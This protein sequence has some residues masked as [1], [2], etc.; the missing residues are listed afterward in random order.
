MSC[1][2]FACTVALEGEAVLAALLEIV[3]EH[4]LGDAR[5]V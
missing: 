1:T 2:A 5:E 4:G 3:V